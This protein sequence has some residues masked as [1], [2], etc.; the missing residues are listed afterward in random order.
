ICLGDDVTACVGSQVSIDICGG[1]ANNNVYTLN[2]ATAYPLGDDDFTGVINLGFDFD[3]Y[4]NT[5]N[6][7]IVGDNG[8]L[9]FNVANANGYCSWVVDPVPTNTASILNSILFPWQDLYNPAGGDI[10]YQTIG[11]APNR[12]GVVFFDGLSMFS[13][14]CQTPDQCFT[15]GV[16]LFEGSNRIETHIANKTTCA[17]WGSGT[18]THGLNNIDGSIGQAVP[19]RNNTVWTAQ[20]DGWEFVPTSP[21]NYDINQIPFGIITTNTSNG[22][23][24]MDTQG[25]TYPYNNGILDVTVQNGTEGYFLASSTCNTGVGSVSDTSFITGVTV[26]VTVNSTDDFCS[27]G[28]GEATASASGGDGSYTYSWDD[29]MNQTGATATGL[30]QGTYTVTATDGMGCQA[31]ESVTIG[32]TPIDLNTTYTQVSC[33]GG[34]DGTATVD[35][36]PAPTSATYDWFDAGNQDTQTATGL[37]AGTY[38]VAIETNLGC[39][40]TATVTVDE[41]P[42]MV[43]NLV[44]SS[45]VTC[46]SGN[47]GEA[48][49][50]ITGGTSPYSYSWQNSSSTSETATDLFAGTNTVTVTDDN[51]CTVDF[52]VDIDEPDALQ[53]LNMA[54]DTIACVGDFV[55][56]HAEG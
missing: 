22:I 43:V 29:P 5:Y 10:Y 33:P 54:V 19:G 17:S 24:W 4:G 46:N 42:E 28:I 30:Y 49:V 55:L 2:N 56:L 6:Q 38:N 23:V 50:E 51:G 41:I 36:V 35:I 21:T 1:G 26:N 37:Q 47:D 11:T 48:I 8:V 32:D 7:I 40:D 16:L 27:Q 45:D 15:G 12:V 34:N 3:F 13:G 25:N 44:S 31:T 20:N 52:D 9:S 18:A 39:Q 14:A 53:I